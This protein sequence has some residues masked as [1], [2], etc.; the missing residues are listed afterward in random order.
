[1]KKRSWP[2]FAMPPLP[3]I[4]FDEQDATLFHTPKGAAYADVL[5]NGHRETWPINSKSFHNIIRH[6]FYKNRGEAPSSGELNRALQQL[7]AQAQFDGPERDVHVRVGGLGGKIYFDLCDEEW[8]AV[9]VDSNGWRL[10]HNPPLRFERKPGMRPLPVPAKGGSIEAL[11]SF[12]NVRSDDDFVIA[13][14]WVL[15]ALRDCGP[16]P[17]LV[18]GG[19]QGSG[20]STFTR[21]L[22]SLVDPN[23]APLRALPGGERD[24]FISASNAHVSAFDNLS[25][26]LPRT[27]DILC[28]LS[29]GGGHSTRKLFS[30]Q[31]ETLFDATKPQILN[32]IEDVVKRA[33]LADR[34][35]FLHL[36]AIPEERRRPEAEFWAEFEVELPRIFGALLD[37]VAKG[38]AMLPK[39]RLE[40]L[41]RMADF[42]LWGTACE[43]ALWP[44]GTFLK[45]YASNRD[46]ADKIIIDSDPVT[47]AV[48]DLMTTGTEWVGTAAALLD[49]LGRLAGDGIT[50]IKGWPRTPQELSHRLR[51]GATLL[52]RSGIE[53]EFDRKGH[54]RTRMIYITRVVPDKKGAQSSASSASSAHTQ[55]AEEADG[56][57]VQGA[58]GADGADGADAKFPSSEM[59]AP[60]RLH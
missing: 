22:R 29:T 43:T 54:A 56:F 55:K 37:G 41:P 1:M 28:R 48:L 31:D 13:V 52:R 59:G 24:F 8:R 53:I 42:A 12:L 33:D 60:V 17:I 14:A 49:K 27:S 5:I 11:R 4:P 32:G 35:V 51:R 36:E 10:V 50:R 18:L 39:T 20:K 38:L 30:D 34:A 19:E 47:A 57:T 46:D 45:A 58:H 44:A 26:L 6:W 7:E 15:A 21:V 25:S 2:E 3:K 23:T 9:E 16:Y 40:K